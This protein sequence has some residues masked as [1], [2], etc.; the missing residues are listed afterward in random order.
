[1]PQSFCGLLLKYFL[2]GILDHNT[3]LIRHP[4]VT[5][6]VHN[7]ENATLLTS[8]GHEKQSTLLVGVPAFLRWLFRGEV[9]YG[10]NRSLSSSRNIFPFIALLII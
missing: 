10:S 2:A 9:I 8:V 5:S 3:H 7:V 4:K 6:V 1:M